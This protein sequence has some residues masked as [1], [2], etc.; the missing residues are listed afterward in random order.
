MKKFFITDNGKPLEIK[1]TKTGELLGYLP[2]YAVWDNLG[3]NGQEVAETSSDL[4]RL[5]EKF[6][7]SKDDV[8]K[9][10]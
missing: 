3:S 8:Y 6:N 1:S 2:R 4:P 10:K 9:I 7:L 5:L